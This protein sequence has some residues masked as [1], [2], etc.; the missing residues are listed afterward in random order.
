MNMNIYT[1]FSFI[2]KSIQ[3]GNGQLNVYRMPQCLH[4]ILRFGLLF[5]HSKR[6]VASFCGRFNYLRYQSSYQRTVTFVIIDRITCCLQ[7][8]ITKLFNNFNRQPSKVII[9]RFAFVANFELAT[10]R[11]SIKSDA[12]D[13]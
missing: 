10:S 13:V 5:C 2:N 1:L 11:V 9:C 8:S 6:L 7:C 4:A 3:V 12:S